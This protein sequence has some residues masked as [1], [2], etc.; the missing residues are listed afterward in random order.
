MNYKNYMMRHVYQ[1][2]CGK[3]NSG[4]DIFNASVANVYDGDIIT[5]KSVAKAP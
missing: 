4:L 1:L 2:L 3:S 5:L